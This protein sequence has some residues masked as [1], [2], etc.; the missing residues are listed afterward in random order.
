D[1]EDN[2][3]L[4]L[5]FP[6]VFLKVRFRLQNAFL[7]TYL[8]AKVNVLLIASN[9]FRDPTPIHHSIQHAI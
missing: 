1:Q 5:I 7:K 6:N 9:C 8:A 2:V 3:I 4:P